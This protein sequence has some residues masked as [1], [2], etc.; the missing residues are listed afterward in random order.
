MDKRLFIAAIA[1]ASL[2]G[3][4]AIFTATTV[5]IAGRYS[6]A[7]LDD[8]CAASG[9]RGY[10]SADKAYGCSR[11][12]VTVECRNDGT[13]KGYVYFRLASEIPA[14]GDPAALLLPASAPGRAM[15]ENA[16]D[17]LTQQ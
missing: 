11:R 12:N 17:V 9:G 2:V 1:A 13:C 10:G 15:S 4:D 3:L 8:I 14:A 6:K 16:G 7:S 5:P